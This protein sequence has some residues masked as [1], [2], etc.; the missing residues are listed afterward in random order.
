MKSE[1]SSGNKEQRKKKDIR[2]NWNI[3]RLMKFQFK[4]RPKKHFLKLAL[5]IGIKTTKS[6]IETWTPFKNKNT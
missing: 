5:W 3:Q 6:T 4:V 1:N 2:N